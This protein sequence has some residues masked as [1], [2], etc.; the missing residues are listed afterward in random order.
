M[1]ITEEAKA[2]FI[3]IIQDS[4]RPYQMNIEIDKPSNTITFTFN[5]VD[6][7]DIESLI[8]TLGEK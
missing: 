6:E 5:D 2:E 4:E 3:E 1:A 8:E 7:Q